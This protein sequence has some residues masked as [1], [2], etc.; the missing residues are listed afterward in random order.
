MI[1]SLITLFLLASLQNTPT[2]VG[3][4]LRAATLFDPVAL[5]EVASVPTLKEGATKPVIQAG[6][7]LVMDAASGVTLFEKNAYTKMPIAS[8]TKIMTAILILDAHKLD[9]VVRVPDSYAGLEG[10]R[11]WLQRG[12]R[13]TVENLLIGLLVRSGGDAALALAT[14]HSESVTNFVEAMN[15]RAKTLGLFS[16]H[17]KNPIGLDEEGAY[18]TAHDLA[19]LTQYAMR[20]RDFRRIVQ[21]TSATI[22]SVDGRISH[23]FE[24]TNKLLNSYLN[25]LGV[26]T[27]TTDAA[28]E[29]VINW[30]RGPK[31]H[32][33][34][35]VILDSPNRFQE[36]KALLDWAF[37]W[38][39]Y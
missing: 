14:H 29:S 18:S 37:R 33:V 38:T 27:G 19:V 34:I 7:A 13:I 26:K 35:A 31:G 24:N 1:R 25:V 20:S 8:L 30:A 4:D 15:A 21:M 11:I 36:N 10:T 32:E 12:E 28:G 3:G 9:E 23:S 16:T 6:A 39:K 2:R 5:L 22:T 17:F